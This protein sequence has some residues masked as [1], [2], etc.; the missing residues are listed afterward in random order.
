VL[1]RPE[2]KFARDIP[3]LKEFLCDVPNEIMNRLEKRQSGLLEIAQGFQLSYL[4]PDFYPHCTSR[5][6]TTMAGMDD[7]MIPVHYAGHVI[8]NCR[9][10]PIRINNKKYI[11]ISGE[12][13]GKHLTW[14]EVQA[15][16]PHE[17]YEGNSGPGYDD[18]EELT[19]EELTKSSGSKTPIMEMTSVTRLPRRVFTFSRKNLIDAIKYNK[20]NGNVFL[21]VNFMNYVDSEITNMNGNYDLSDLPIKTQ[22]WIDRY[23]K[24]YDDLIRFIGTGPNLEDQIVVD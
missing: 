3:E 5:N 2:A 7:A 18:Q 23:I 10:Y 19:W 9:T 6:C 17:V 12:Y 21:S 1:R 20:A 15:G 22:S 13:K 8:I 11:G 4:L 14:A 24:P 16:I